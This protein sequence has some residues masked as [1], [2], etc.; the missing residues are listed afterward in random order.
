MLRFHSRIVSVVWFW[1]RNG[2]NSQC[3]RRQGDV[4]SINL[5]KA[6]AHFDADEI[7]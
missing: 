2:V 7:I 6:Y 5:A 3:H 1:T 4:D